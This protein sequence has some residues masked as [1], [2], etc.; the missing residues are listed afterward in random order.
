MARF[1]TGVRS[2]LPQGLFVKLA[3]YRHQIFVKTLQWNLPTTC[4]LELDEFDT[5]YAVYTIAVGSDGS[6]AGCARLLPTTRPYLLAS[7]FPELVDGPPPNSPSVWELSRFAASRVNSCRTT[8]RAIAG[9]R[10]S[11]RLFAEAI[12]QAR[13]RGAE[14]VVGVVSRP[15]ERFLTQIGLEHQPL[16]RRSIIERETMSGRV[17]NLRNHEEWIKRVGALPPAGSLRA[18]GSHCR[19]LAQGGHL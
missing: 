18:P 1:V 3:Q 11:R 14:K 2:E 7:V 6:V 16:G 4:E 12:V 15:I 8:E 10:L 19:A 13:L 9:Q 5:E 17:V